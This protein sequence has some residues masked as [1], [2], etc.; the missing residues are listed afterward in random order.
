MFNKEDR[1][2]CTATYSVHLNDAYRSQNEPTLAVL[3]RN[4]VDLFGASHQHQTQGAT[5]ALEARSLRSIFADMTWGAKPV[6]EALGAVWSTLVK[7]ARM[8][9]DAERLRNMD[10]RMLRDIGLTRSEV[11]GA[12]RHGRLVK[13]HADDWF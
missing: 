1:N 4:V 12:V 13:H 11:E 10:D 7:H 5:T 2:A 9:R 8:R 3:E 6:L